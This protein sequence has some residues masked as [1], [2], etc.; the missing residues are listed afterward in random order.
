MSWSIYPL[1][2]TEEKAEN[3]PCSCTRCR[4]MCSESCPSFQAQYSQRPDAGCKYEN[5]YGVHG[6][7]VCKD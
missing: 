7:P 3:D 1:K 2:R 6:C 5:L 4:G